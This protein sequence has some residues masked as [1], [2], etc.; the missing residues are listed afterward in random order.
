MDIADKWYVVLTKPKQ[1]KRA[2][3]HLRRQGYRCFLPFAGNP[4]KARR[5]GIVCVIEPL[6][7]RYLFIQPGHGK[8]SFAPVRST[9]GVVN[10]VTFGNK[11][12]SLSTIT[13]EQIKS[14]I[15]EK[16]GLIEL[17]PTEY[18]PG[19]KVRI[20][21]GSL[22]GLEGVFEQSVS[23]SRVIM[24]LNLLGRQARVQVGRHVLQPAP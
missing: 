24:L 2:A 8:Q 10:L 21:D 7:P 20:S 9:Q 17:N 6:F 3:E 15:N 18:R 16:S 12:A 11:L 19:D 1:E 5:R 14:R 22:A 13:I 23:E 4:N